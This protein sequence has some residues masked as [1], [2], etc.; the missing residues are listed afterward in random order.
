MNPELIERPY[1]IE[2]YKEQQRQE[3]PPTVFIW[4][5]GIGFSSGVLWSVLMGWIF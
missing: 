5:L 3:R 1:E 2:Y 4:G